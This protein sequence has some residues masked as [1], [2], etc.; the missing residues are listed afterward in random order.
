MGTLVLPLQMCSF[1]LALFSILHLH[2]ALSVQG[3][4]SAASALPRVAV[5]WARTTL[6]SLRPSMRQIPALKLMSF[7]QT[8]T[9]LSQ[10]HGTQHAVS[11][12]LAKNAQ[13]KTL[14]PECSHA[15]QT[16]QYAGRVPFDKVETLK[17]LPKLCPARVPGEDKYYTVSQ[18]PRLH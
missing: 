11:N 6:P 16:L 7:P 12:N 17:G 5:G 2:D 1:M 18:Q 13:L 8:G 9:T 14:A 4:S 10:T 3:L 15:L